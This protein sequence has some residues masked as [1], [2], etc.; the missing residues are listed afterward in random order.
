MNTFKQALILYLFLPSCLLFSEQKVASCDLRGGLGNQLFQIVTT[1]AYAWDHGYTPVFERLSFSPTRTG[2]RPV[3]WDSVF[4]QVSTFAMGQ[5]QIQWNNFHGS[6]GYIPIKCEGN[7]IKLWGH[8]ESPRYFDHHRQKIQKIFSLPKN[9]EK[10]VDQKFRKIA[11]G[12]KETVSV[13]IRRDDQA[14]SNPLKWLIDL[15]EDSDKSYYA[16]ALS[17]FPDATVVVFCDQPKWAKNFIGKMLQ[18]RSVHYVH[19]EDYIELF[20]MARCT[21]NII[22]NSTFSWW[23][24]YLNQ[25]P[26]KKI[27]TPKFFL[28][29]PKPYNLP[30]NFYYRPE[31]IMPNWIVIEN[32]RNLPE[33]RKNWK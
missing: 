14:G 26:N 9:L 25:N 30:E 28:Y 32:N 17:F 31:L 20:L 10:I 21:H 15:W 24:A 23:G 3:Y 13:H 19:D 2:Q 16:K 1:S 33:R 4:H 29:D 8:F 22:A 18:G 7:A 12:A 27:V 5:L 11:K 6:D